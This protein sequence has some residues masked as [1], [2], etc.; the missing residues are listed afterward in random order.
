MAR[1][2]VNPDA[3]AHAEKLI[4]AHR[5][6]LDSNWGEAQPN[7]EAQNAY[8]EK[9]GWEEYARWHLGLTD[10]AGDQTKARFAFAIGDFTRVHRSGLI[11]CVY[12]AAEWRHKDVERAAYALLTKLDEVAGIDDVD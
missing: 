3:V 11:A 10:G 8:L 4:A 12:R 1:Y 5:Y 9:H 2:R 6:V 7:T